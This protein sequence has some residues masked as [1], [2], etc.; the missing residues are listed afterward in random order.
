MSANTPSAYKGFNLETGDRILFFLK[1]GIVALVFLTFGVGATAI[2]AAAACAAMAY[3]WFYM[4][5]S[6]RRFDEP[7]VGIVLAAG[8][9][10]PFTTFAVGA[11][12]GAA[13]AFLGGAFLLMMGPRD[14]GL[15]VKSALG[16]WLSVSLASALSGCVIIPSTGWP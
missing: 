8:A 3:E 2:L 16:S 10:P 13:V 7:L 12:G 15:L 11:A 9:V 14:N 6:G 1:V 4:T 5:T